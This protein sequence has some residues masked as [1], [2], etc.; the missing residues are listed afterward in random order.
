MT[1]KKK[2]GKPASL[3]L[4]QEALILLSGCAVTGIIAGGIVGIIAGLI[5]KNRFF[6]FG[7]LVGGTAGMLIGYPVGIITGLVLG[8]KLLR[9]EGSLWLGIIGCL[10]GSAGFLAAAEAFQIVA[11]YSLTAYFIIAPVLG[12]G[13]FL[14]GRVWGKKKRK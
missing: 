12:A 14:L 11:A 8:R 9:F 10:A 1:K 2:P 5:L 3:K 7:G 13:L 6:G 4:W